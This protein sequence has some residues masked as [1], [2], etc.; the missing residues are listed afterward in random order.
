MWKSVKKQLM[1][2]YETLLYACFVLKEKIILK[3]QQES[4]SNLSI[5]QE[6]FE[7]VKQNVSRIL[8]IYNVNNTYGLKN[9]TSCIDY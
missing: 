7:V 8:N 4:K 5:L 9:F 1:S 3:I 6:V 2:D